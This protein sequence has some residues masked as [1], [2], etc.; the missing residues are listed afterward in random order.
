[1]SAHDDQQP[2]KA[3]ARISLLCAQCK[4]RKVKCDRKLPC[5]SCVKHNVPETCGYFG[6]QVVAQ[7]SETENGVSV[8]RAFADNSGRAFKSRDSTVKHENTVLP[9]KSPPNGPLSGL[10]RLREGEGIMERV[11]KQ[12]ADDFSRSGNDGRVYG[13]VPNHRQFEK[14]A[15]T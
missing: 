6:D 15:G 1:M 5:L 12:F 3:R 4:R 11:P 9:R 8:F 10:K 13:S 7:A 14:R 2:T